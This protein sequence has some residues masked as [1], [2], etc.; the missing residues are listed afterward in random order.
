MHRSKKGGFALIYVIC[1]VV[2][3]SALTLSALVLL[4]TN[5]I[6]SAHIER[7]NKAQLAAETGIDKGIS[8]L[9]AQIAQKVGWAQYLEFEKDPT[10][11]KH[12]YTGTN[13][14]TDPDIKTLNIS[15]KELGGDPLYKY[16][17]DFDNV[18]S[19]YD[20]VTGTYKKCIKITS[21]GK[22]QSTIKTITACIDEQ[23]ISNIYFDRLFNNPLTSINND[24]SDKFTFNEPA[25]G[26]DP[27]G[28]NNFTVVKSSKENPDGTTTEA[29]WDLI[30]YKE[31]N[32][33]TTSLE[34]IVSKMYDYIES[35]IKSGDPNWGAT[36]DDIEESWIPT[37]KKL[38]DAKKKMLEDEKDSPEYAKD[39]AEY[40]KDLAEYNNKIKNYNLDDY[41]KIV[42]KDGDNDFEKMLQYSTFYKVIFINGDIDASDMK[43][44]LV[45][46]VIY[47]SGDIN[48]GSPSQENKIRLWNCN[49]YANTITIGRVHYKISKSE[50]TNFTDSNK[51]IAYYNREQG[52]VI[53]RSNGADL[54]P[55]PNVEIMGVTSNRSK[56][57]ILRYIMNYDDDHEP[58]SRLEGYY[59]ELD[60]NHKQHAE[61]VFPSEAVGQFSPSDRVAINDF[62]L[63]NINEY[64]YGL[65]FRII[66][67]EEK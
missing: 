4:S 15:D 56:E 19:Q 23:N 47:C 8:K 20:S 32:S 27:S 46:Y 9:K 25:T 63:K 57:S 59:N 36:K 3:L 10:N 48:F 24:G 58:Y 54:N 31:N 13:V 30:G 11:K 21:T 16:S 44:P 22:Y 1:V 42:N 2:I 7:V 18:D 5:R 39:L 33:K 37:S 28:N 40:E 12:I 60:P 52:K 53:F 66:D 29:K 43:R 14:K 65:K 45:N 50:D 62:L 35:N 51:D 64:A 34:T 17:V 49:I 67:W 6:S 55:Q 61:S 41:I 38:E 26:G